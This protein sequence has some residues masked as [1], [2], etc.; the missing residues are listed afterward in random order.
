MHKRKQHWNIFDACCC[1]WVGLG[2]GLGFGVG[3]STLHSLKNYAK[4][5]LLRVSLL[6]FNDNNAVKV[7]MYNSMP[8]FHGM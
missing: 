7:D 4:F 3:S 8:F 2:V 1:V 5:V 6:H